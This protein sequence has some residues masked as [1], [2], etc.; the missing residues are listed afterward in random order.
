MRNKQDLYKD[1][2][3]VVSYTVV[4]AQKLHTFQMDVLACGHFT[5]FLPLSCVTFKKLE[6]KLLVDNLIYDHRR[7]WVYSLCKDLFRFILEVSK[8]Y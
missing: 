6:V 4:L 3:R 1:L 8:S 7:Q 2:S 5:S